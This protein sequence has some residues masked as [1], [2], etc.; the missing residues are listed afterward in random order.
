MDISFII[1]TNSKD[2]S[3]TVQVVESILRCPLKTEV[4]IVSPDEPPDTQLVKWVK[5]EK[6]TGSCAAFNLGATYATGDY[7][8]I[9]PDDWL[10]NPGWWSVIDFLEH[11]RTPIATL[12]KGGNFFMKRSLYEGILKKHIFN[13][14]YYHM[15]IDN[16]LKTRL[17]MDWRIIVPEY[18]VCDA[19]PQIQDSDVDKM[20]SKKKYYR[21]DGMIFNHFWRTSHLLYEY[22]LESDDILQQRALDRIRSNIYQ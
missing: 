13:P 9:T 11:T 1:A 21:I 12:Y 2:F 18:T 14:C 6:P 20:M 8:A 10:L 4:I 22:A 19:V 5:E 17:L 16:D 7:I 15:Y 3:G